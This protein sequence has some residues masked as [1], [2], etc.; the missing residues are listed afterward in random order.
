MHQHSLNCSYKCI[1]TC[2]SS[3]SAANPKSPMQGMLLL[4]IVTKQCIL[5]YKC[6]SHYIYYLSNVC[7]SKNV[8]N[9]EL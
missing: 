2:L 8:A 5:M 4:L 1:S 9:T 6:K 3:T 7:V